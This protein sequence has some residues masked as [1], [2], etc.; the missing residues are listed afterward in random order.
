[1]ASCGLERRTLNDDFVISVHA[2]ERFQERFPSLWT[3]DDDIGKQIYDETMDAIKEGRI[4]SIPP[5]EFANHDLA[6]WLVS[7]SK[8]VWTPNKRRGYVLVEGNDGMTV[9]TVLVGQPTNEARSKLYGSRNRKENRGTPR[10]G[11]D[12]STPGVE[13]SSA[14]HDA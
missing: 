11:A 6:R 10:H 3:N 4:A 13:T 2:L 5:L 9:A 7:K 8:I 14:P 12:S 1:M